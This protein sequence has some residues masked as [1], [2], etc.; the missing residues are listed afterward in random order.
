MNPK[1]EKLLDVLDTRRAALALQR[2]KL[3]AQNDRLE[4]FLR[5]VVVLD[6]THPAVKR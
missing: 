5:G 1:L 4:N 6:A 3:T 2:T